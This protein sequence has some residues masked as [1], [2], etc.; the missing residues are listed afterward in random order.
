MR[1]RLGIIGPTA[2]LG[3]RIR[4]RITIPKAALFI[5]GAYSAFRRK[6]SRT[7]SSVGIRLAGFGRGAEGQWGVFQGV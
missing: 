2:T 6:V 3:G 7:I 5:R 1:I 4:L